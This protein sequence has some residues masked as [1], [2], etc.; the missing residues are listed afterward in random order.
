MKRSFG[1]DLIRTLSV[2]IVIF[3]HYKVTEGFNFGL[4]AIDYLFVISGYLI[5]QI[6]LKDFYRSESTSFSTATHFMIRRWFRILP[7][8]YFAIFL[9]FLILPDI[10][11]NIVYYILFLQNHFYGIDF[12]PVTWTLVIDEWF[13]LGAPLL[14]YG[15]LR[16]F[17]HAPRKGLFFLIAVIL[18]IN[19]LRMAWVMYS[20]ASFES[21]V[22]NV[23]FRQDTLVIGVL[24]AYIKLHYK[25]AFDRLNTPVVFWTSFAAFLAVVTWIGMISGE[26]FAGMNDYFWTRT[27]GF[28]LIAILITATMPYFENSVKPIPFKPLNFLNKAVF[29]ISMYSYALY[30]FH[31]EVKDSIEYLFPSIKSHL[32]L[33]NITC[34]AAVVVLSFILHH[35]LEK[36]MLRIRDKH[37]PDKKFA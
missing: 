1:I 9:K 36:P 21:L 26:K 32:L 30:L 35:I 33:R 8:Y 34:I 15:F 2:I 14:L 23:P 19:L 25:K 18:G 24:A 12:Y 6:L 17:G 29:Q 27:Y 5:G 22:G 3:R 10:G 31:L 16:I 37:F 13:Y 28:S 4:Y 20:G 11:S 7:L